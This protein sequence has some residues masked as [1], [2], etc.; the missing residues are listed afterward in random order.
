MRLVSASPQGINP[1]Q[2]ILDLRV[3]E[4]PGVWPQIVTSVS[5]RYDQSPS[6]DYDSVLIREPDG[7]TVVVD[8]DVVS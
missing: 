8:V 2:L 4:L 3:T 1:H 7:D 6:I 5:V